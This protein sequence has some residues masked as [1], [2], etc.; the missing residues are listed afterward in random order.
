M[1][2]RAKKN[3]KKV[4]ASMHELTTKM[5]AAKARERKEEIQFKK[6]VDAALEV[7][8]RELEQCERAR[9]G[10]DMKLKRECQKAEAQAKVK[11]MQ[12]MAMDARLRAKEMAEKKACAAANAQ[13]ATESE[14][15]ERAKCAEEE[16]AKEELAAAKA[17]LKAA[18]DNVSSIEKNCKGGAGAKAAEGKH[19]AEKAKAEAKAEASKKA[20]A[21]KSDAKA[22]A[23]AAAAEKVAAKT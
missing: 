8:M 21:A 18:Q 9:I 1:L 11:A 15:V 12:Q 23:K 22:S 14:A 19:H 10:A 5:E 3:Q 4:H 13:K 20:S 7:R 6:E 17:K 2:E 16:K